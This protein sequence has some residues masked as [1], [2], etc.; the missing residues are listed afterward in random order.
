[1]GQDMNF[2]SYVKYIFIIICVLLIV[3]S[4][5][6]INNLSNERD[7]YL[8]ELTQTN[9]LLKTYKEKTDEL[10]KL[11]EDNNATI[12]QLQKD[13]EIVK[14]NL[15]KAN[16]EVL[17]LQADNSAIIS[18]LVGTAPKDNKCQDNF[19]W[20]IDSMIQLGNGFNK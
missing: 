8:I 6:Y 14:S 2:I 19:K 18:D 15:D 5:I 1:M 10:A 9:E 4:G 13:A 3:A 17:K 7:K 11:N 12:E 20:M 16:D